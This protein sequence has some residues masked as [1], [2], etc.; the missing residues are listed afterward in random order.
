ME[1]SDLS[2]GTSS[3]PSCLGLA[4]HICIDPQPFVD[5]TSAQDH[6]SIFSLIP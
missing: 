2:G 3:L 4:S 5:L 6:A 1:T